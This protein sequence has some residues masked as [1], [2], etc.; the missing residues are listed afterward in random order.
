MSEYPGIPGILRIGLR[1]MLY[2]KVPMSEYPG[3]PGILRISLRCICYIKGAHV[4]VSWD[5][6]DTWD[7]SKNVTCRICTRGY[8]GHPGILTY[9]WDTS[10]N[11][12]I[13]TY[14]CMCHEWCQWYSLLG[15]VEHEKN[16]CRYTMLCIS[17]PVNYMYNTVFQLENKVRCIKGVHSKRA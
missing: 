7:R 6:W 10:K 8:P 2:W 17:S 9:P 14:A 13:Y 5:S 16:T 4:G 15:L 3:I 12:Y 11:R 1:C